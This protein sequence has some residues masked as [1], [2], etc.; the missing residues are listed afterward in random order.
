[1]AA[2]FMETQRWISFFKPF[3][4]VGDLMVIWYGFF[5]PSPELNENTYGYTRGLHHGDVPIMK[6]FGLTHQWESSWR[7]QKMILMDWNS[8][9]LL[10][11]DVRWLLI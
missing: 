5:Y 11:S 8:L 9:D 3:A 10:F 1:M 4:D 7:C 2:N 6:H